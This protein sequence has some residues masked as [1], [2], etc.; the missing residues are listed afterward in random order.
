VRQPQRLRDTLIDALALVASYKADYP[1][2]EVVRECNLV[3]ERGRQV[4]EED[5]D[6][7]IRDGSSSGNG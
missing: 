2:N 5:R 3:L 6:E 7:C 4:L 1:D